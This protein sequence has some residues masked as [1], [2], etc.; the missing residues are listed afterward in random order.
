VSLSENIVYQYGTVI[1][2]EDLRKTGGHQDQ[3]RSRYLSIKHHD[4]TPIL[5]LAKAGS[6]LKAVRNSL[7]ILKTAHNLQRCL[8]IPEGFIELVERRVSRAHHA[9]NVSVLFVVSSLDGESCFP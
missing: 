3:N 4:A 6:R 9:E 1:V 7:L 2:I 5:N 8:K